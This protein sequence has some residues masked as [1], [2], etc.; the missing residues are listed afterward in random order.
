MA[1]ESAAVAAV[2]RA[3]LARYASSERVL[4]E[5]AGISRECPQGRGL[6]LER[7]PFPLEQHR[8]SEPGRSAGQ[9]PRCGGALHGQKHIYFS[10]ELRQGLHCSP[11]GDERPSFLAHLLT[12]D[13]QMPGGL[14]DVTELPI[15]EAQVGVDTERGRLLGGSIS[16]CGGRRYALHDCQSLLIGL[17]GALECSG[18]MVDHAD[19][20][21]CARIRQRRVAARRDEVQ[22]S[23]C[24]VERALWLVAH[25]EQPARLPE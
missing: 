4:A 24:G 9:R 2:P 25:E 5:L 22:T 23:C 8:K 13:L 16:I 19:V 6:F 14:R 11:F 7:K 12:S 15:R 18:T 1:S 17:H 3:S 10:G 20:V 21:Q